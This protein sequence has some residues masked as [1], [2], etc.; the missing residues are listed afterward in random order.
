[1]FSQRGRSVHMLASPGADGDG[2]SSVNADH[3]Q[4]QHAQKRWRVSEQQRTS[5]NRFER[6]VLPHLD[7]AYTLARYLIREP[8]D[9]EDAMQ[10]A[11]LQAIRY[12]DTLRNDSEARGWLLAI[13]RRECYAAWSDRRARM[14]TVSLDSDTGAEHARLQLVDRGELP[15][16]AAGRNS[17]QV[18]IAE[19]VDEL[20]ERLREVIILRELQQCSYEEIAMVIEAPIGTVMSRLSRGRARLAAALRAVIDLSD[21]S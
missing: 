19:A 15:D 3:A 16:E 5:G 2:G 21:V 20:P 1:M 4:R 9:A 7:A 14:N 12:V 17:V 8:A 6:V 13:V 10:E 11:V 18:K